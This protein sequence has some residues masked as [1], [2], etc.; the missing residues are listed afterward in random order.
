MIVNVILIGEVSR[1]LVA[2]F[3][4][5]TN[6]IIKHFKIFKDV[7]MQ[8]EKMQDNMLKKHKIMQS[9]DHVQRKQLMKE[10]MDM[11]HE[12]K[13][14]MMG[15]GMMVDDGKDPAMGVEMRCFGL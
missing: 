3:C 1:Y 6:A 12:G 14:G 13:E 5:L 7:D 8:M 2:D 9:K 4:V 11:M 15:S 10:H